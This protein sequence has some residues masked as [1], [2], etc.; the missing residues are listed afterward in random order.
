MTPMGRQLDRR[1]GLSRINF[2][3]VAMLACCLGVAGCGELAENSEQLEKVKAFDPSTLD[4][5]EEDL[6]LVAVQPEPEV[7]EAEYE[8]PNPNRKNPFSQPQRRMSAGVMQAEQGRVHLIGFSKVRGLAAVL[9][10]N[11]ETMVLREGEVRDD[12]RVVAIQP[13][14]V[15]L[16]RNNIRQILR[17]AH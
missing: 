2:C 14:E 5:L 1:D 8:F 17:L 7:D 6:Q 9:V 12:L 13:P 15:A 11:G 16:E 3:S 10:W 4:H